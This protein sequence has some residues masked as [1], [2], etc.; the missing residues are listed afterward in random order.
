MGNTELIYH[1]LKMRDFNKSFKKEEKVATLN[2]IYKM[3]GGL[4]D[5]DLRTIAKNSTQKKKVCRKCYVR[6]A[7]GATNCRKKKCGHSNQLRLK[8]KLKEEKKKKKHKI[9]QTNFYI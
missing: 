9:I 8:K 5:S 6:L 2:I 3:N 4:I 1:Y 7:F